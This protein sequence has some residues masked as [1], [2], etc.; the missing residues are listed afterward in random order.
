MDNFKTGQ[1]IPT[2]QFKLEWIKEENPVNLDYR[3]TLLGA[4]EP[5]NFM[6]FS[7]SPGGRG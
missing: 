7:I 4:K 3:L 6:Y 2:C 5:F 1:R